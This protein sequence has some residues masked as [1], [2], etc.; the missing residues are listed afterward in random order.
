MVVCGAG[1]IILHILVYLIYVLYMFV[2]SLLWLGVLFILF[3]FIAELTFVP[4]YI[5]I[6]LCVSCDVGDYTRVVG[7][8]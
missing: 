6:L 3:Q 2:Y 4:V 5:D 7:Q 1:S 8:W